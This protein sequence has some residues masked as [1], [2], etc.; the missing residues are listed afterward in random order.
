MP[1]CGGLRRWHGASFRS[2]VGI[3]VLLGL[4]EFSDW[5]LVQVL[6]DASHDVTWQTGHRHPQL[7]PVP[8]KMLCSSERFLNPRAIIFW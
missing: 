6:V 4:L 3:R 8:G 7:V 5:Q 1:L 2:S